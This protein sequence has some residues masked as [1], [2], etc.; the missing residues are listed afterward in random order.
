MHCGCYSHFSECCIILKYAAWVNCFPNSHQFRL[1]N[2]MGKNVKADKHFANQMFLYIF[3]IGTIYMDN[4]KQ[5]LQLWMQKC[6]C[7]VSYFFQ[8]HCTIQNSKLFYIHS[9]P[10]LWMTEFFIPCWNIFSLYFRSGL[11]A[12]QLERFLGGENRLQRMYELFGKP[13]SMQIWNE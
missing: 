12:L 6:Y 4:F 10:V 8:K 1:F 2:K 11:F 13:N 3:L 7:T 9:L 5:Y